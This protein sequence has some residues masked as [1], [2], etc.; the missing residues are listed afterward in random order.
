MRTHLEGSLLPGVTPTQPSQVR[1]QH[2]PDPSTKSKD[3][4]PPCND[5][6]KPGAEPG[7][8]PLTPQASH[9]HF[10]RCCCGLLT[11]GSLPGILRERQPLP[12]AP[13]TTWSASTSS[14]RFLEPSAPRNVSHAV[15]EPHPRCVFTG[16]RSRNTTSTVLL[17]PHLPTHPCNSTP[18]PWDPIF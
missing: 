4:L 11:S 14:S 6:Q 16:N 5:G 15:S 18:A 8:C 7:P 3:C 17:S 9:L 2:K 13:S 12:A 1:L 10:P